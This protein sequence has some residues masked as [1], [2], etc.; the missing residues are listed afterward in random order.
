M[1][2]HRKR[3]K[4]AVLL[5][6]AG[7]LS[8]CSMSSKETTP[9]K[10]GITFALD[11]VVEQTWYG[12]QGEETYLDVVKHLSEME[13]KLS[14]Y[15][16]GGELDRLNQA[17]GEEYVPLSEDTFQTLKKAKEWS[18]ASE[19]VFDITIAPVTTL[20]GITGENPQ[21]PN[22]ETLQEKLSLVN[23]QDIL[24]DEETCSAKLAKKGMAVD[25]GGIAKGML[26]DDIRQIAEQNGT[27]SGFVSLG[28]NILTIG[29]KPNGSDFVFGL[30]DPRGGGGEYIA[31]LTIPGMTMATTGDYERYFE[32]DGVRYHHVIDPRTGYPA[33]TD[34]ISLT[35]VSED[36]AL[37]DFLSTTFFIYGK[38]V[39]LENLEQ[40]EFSLIAVDKEKNV[41]VSPALRENFTPNPEKTGYTFHLEG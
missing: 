10:T 25:L 22:E 36:G 28:G 38:E 6:I 18:I 27:E 24:L 5:A 34:L 15:K 31:T 7:I 13:G 2:L 33:D 23:A 40:E 19:G 11:T 20:W 26:I 16:A 8:S 32:Q 9:S 1:R 14:L 41:Y 35:V 21:I 4:I 3:G 37:A 12:E 39:V 17:A 30:R 29:K